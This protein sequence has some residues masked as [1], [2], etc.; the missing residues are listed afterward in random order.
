MATITIQTTE[1]ARLAAIVGPSAG[2]DR[3]LPV[4]TYL[5]IRSHEGKVEFRATDRYTFAAARGTAQYDGPDTC[6]RHADVKHLM[7]ALK[8]AGAAS[9]TLEIGEATITATAGELMGPLGSAADVAQRIKEERERRGWTFRDLEM[10]TEGAGRRVSGSVLH[11][12]E[13]GQAQ[14]VSVD[15]L[16]SL[17]L[18]FDLSP[19]EILTPFALLRDRR[20]KKSQLD[21]QAVALSIIYQIPEGE[22]PKYNP[23][24]AE[25]T[26]AGTPSFNP[27]NLRRVPNI[28]GEAATFAS[29]GEGKPC[30]FFGSDWAVIIMPIRIAE[31]PLSAW[32]ARKPVAA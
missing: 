15:D 3:F 32:I 13:T 5:Q 29:Q 17:C 20:A 21:E 19:T 25:W 2:K 1:L 27:E 22:F 12:I 4:F 30:G 10:A 31:N 11:R 16:V 28:K 6:I 8:M 9:V 26:A 23:F 7:S 14:K 24:S 18:V